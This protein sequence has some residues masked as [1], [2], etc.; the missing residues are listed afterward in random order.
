M[1]LA[2]TNYARFNASEV[3]L[4]FAPVTFDAATF[5]IWGA[6]LNGARLVVT[7]PGIESL[8]S[9][10]QTIKRKGVTT[11]WLTA[12]LF[13]QMADTELDSLRGVRQLIVGGDVLSATR[14]EVAQTLPSCQLINGYSPTENTTF[15]CCET[16]RGGAS[17]RSVPIGTPISN[18]Q[19]YVLS[20]EMEPVPVGVPGKL[21]IGGD[22]LARQILRDPGA[23][24]ERFVP[25]PF[26]RARGELYRT[27]DQVGYRIDGSLEFLGRLD[28][29]VKIPG[30][31]N[32][33]GRHRVC[34]V[35]ACRHQRMRGRQRR[36]QD[37]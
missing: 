6:L 34:I 19:G 25:N 12:G 27:G 16:L 20:T 17:D 10:S 9:L 30:L 4:Q 21:F 33:A 31:S 26:A 36:R 3:F 8:E 32:R 15:T 7:A 18:M 23:T 11:L 24:A 37:W 28:Q 14:G 2:K 22:G 29:Q 35:T 1:R 5:E 13:H